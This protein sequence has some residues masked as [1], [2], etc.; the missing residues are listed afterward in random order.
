MVPEVKEHQSFPGKP[1][2]IAGWGGRG[3]L[4]G[5]GTQKPGKVAAGAA[6]TKNTPA[7][8]EARKQTL[9]VGEALPRSII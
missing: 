2:S 5:K 8:T 4:T 9:E 7:A 6:T 1:W 3:G